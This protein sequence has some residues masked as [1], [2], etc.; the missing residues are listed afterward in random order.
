MTQQLE[1]QA[2]TVDSL[3]KAPKR[4]GI[5][6]EEIAESFESVGSDIAEIGKL[7]NKEKNAVTAFLDMLKGNMEHVAQSVPIS[8]KI[9]PIEY[10]S[11]SQ[12]HVQPDGQLL[13]GFE[14]GGSKLVDLGDHQNRDLLIVV[15]DDFV[16]KFEALTLQI[17]EQRLRKPKPVAVVEPPKVEVKVPIAVAVPVVKPEPQVAEVV[18]P[19]LPE[20]EPV[21]AEPEAELPLLLIAPAQFPLLPAPKETP[22]PG[23]LPTENPTELLAE[24]NTAIQTITSE[25]LTY[26]DMLGNE[27]FEQEPVSKYFDDW[28]VNL[29]QVIL[30]FESNAAI[31]AD[32]AFSAESNRI[33]G[34]IQTELDSRIQ[35]EAEI[36]TSY[37]TLVENRYL[38]DKIDAE[39]ADQARKFVE[40]GT[41]ALETLMHS[42]YNLEKE[43]AEAQAVKVS[44]RHPLQ[45]IAKDQKVSELT[46]RLNSVKK[47]LALAVG[48]SSVDASN[49]GDIQAQ[50]EAQAKLLEEKRKAAMEFLSKNVDDLANEIAKLKTQKTSNPLRKVAIQQQVFEAEEKLFAA[51]KRLELA[52]R[53]SSAE[54][55][56]LRL[57]YEKKKQVTLGEMQTLEQD[58][59]AKTVDNSAEVRRDAAK[60]LAE[61]VNDLAKRK[62]D[63][64]LEKQKDASEE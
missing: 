31:G 40:K 2:T 38:L 41:S 21:E 27:V 10:G 14:D 61:A 26:L 64:P 4:R 5:S 37:R 48:T 39:H 46:Q 7:S 23:S 28:M 6:V 9:V 60:A 63:A 51:R 57:E 47:R 18:E 45:M 8:A 59:A 42:M 17:A 50:F 62:T 55:E 25:T 54:M 1:T 24:R 36:A 44:I 32:E 49:S 33:F 19:A 3:A 13:L 43:L 35:S 15:M 11:V 52:E 53:N 12:A 30:S 34:Q 16:P 56:Q 58:I 20:P 22:E 29:R